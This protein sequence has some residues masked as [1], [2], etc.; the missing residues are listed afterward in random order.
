MLWRMYQDVCMLFLYFVT[1]TLE[2]VK[3]TA[4]ER[5]RVPVA[6]QG[7]YYKKTIF[8]NFVKNNMIQMH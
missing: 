2:R 5:N 6:V 3:T 7:I 1:S 4:M 8:A